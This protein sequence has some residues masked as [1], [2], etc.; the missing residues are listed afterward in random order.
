MEEKR[1]EEEGGR[2]VREY[3]H[4]DNVR[5]SRN[6]PQKKTEWLK[7]KIYQQ[8]MNSFKNRF[9]KWEKPSFKKI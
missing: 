9:E 1:E 5:S 8:F 7:L 4:N 6:F 2:E 3:F